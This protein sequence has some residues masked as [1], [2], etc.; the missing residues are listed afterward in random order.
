[1][2]RRWIWIATGGL[3]LVL[4]GAILAVV[5]VHYLNDPYRTLEEFPVGKYFDDY[6][7]LAGSKFRADVH[8]EADLGWKDKAGRLMLFSG[9]DD[10]R[11]FAIMIPIGV[12]NG[13]SFDKGQAYTAEVQVKEGGLI[14]AEAFRKD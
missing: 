14:Y 7:S 9:T 8:V 3:F 5:A 4:L 6:Q 10:S 12:A 2:R 11:P 1:M 13:I